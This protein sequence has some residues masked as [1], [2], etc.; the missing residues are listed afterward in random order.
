MNILSI[1]MLSAVVFMMIS[2]G[3][4]LGGSD[5]LRVIKTP[6]D[7]LV[8]L[9]GQTVLLPLT[10]FFLVVLLEFDPFYGIGIMLIACTPGGASSNF[11]TSAVKGDVALSIG[12]TGVANFL[13]VITM[14][15]IM[16][17]TFSSSRGI[18]GKYRSLF[19]IPPN[20]CLSLC[21]CQS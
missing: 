19:G 8:G 21:F 5:F 1:I 10:A 13:S 16:A 20:R 15:L 12:L 18:A 4:N 14:P 7:V 2:L 11:F 6:R 9:V 3:L 17:W